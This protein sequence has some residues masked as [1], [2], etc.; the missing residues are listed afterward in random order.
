MH[1]MILG[2]ITTALDGYS[3]ARTLN[4]PK[5]AGFQTPNIDT[6]RQYDSVAMCPGLPEAPVLRTRQR[7][8]LK[9]YV[10]I[11]DDM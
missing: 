6:P 4:L 11:S 2:S 3:Q 5:T 9:V 10:I 7:L 1:C 8:L